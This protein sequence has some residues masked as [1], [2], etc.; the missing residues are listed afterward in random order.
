MTIVMPGIIFWFL[1]LLFVYC[2]TFFVVNVWEDR[3]W[4]ILML[5]SACV[6]FIGTILYILYAIAWIWSHWHNALHIQL[7]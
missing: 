1:I 5:I 2:L 6:S 4:E 7:T 3:G